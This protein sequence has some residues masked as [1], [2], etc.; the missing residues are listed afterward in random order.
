MVSKVVSKS[1]TQAEYYAK[2]R[3]THPQLQRWWRWYGRKY[4]IRRLRFGK[5]YADAVRRRRIE[6]AKRSGS[7]WQELKRLNKRELKL[8]LDKH[9]MPKGLRAMIT[10]VLAARRNEARTDAITQAQRDINDYRVMA[11]RGR[12]FYERMGNDVAS[13]YEGL[14]DAKVAGKCR[15]GGVQA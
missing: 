8:L 2:L 10:K 15:V 9:R 13:G 14:Q 5:R 11:Y 1:Q 6:C 3:E 12:V 4:A 7:Y